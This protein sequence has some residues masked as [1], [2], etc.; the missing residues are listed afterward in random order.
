MPIK[1]EPQLK[2]PPDRLI[3]FTA[4]IDIG[5][6]T[7]GVFC[8]QCGSKELDETE[9]QDYLVCSECGAILAMRGIEEKGSLQ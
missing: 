4:C 5:E 1:H 9:N 3:K 6:R 2:I 7:Y 8:C